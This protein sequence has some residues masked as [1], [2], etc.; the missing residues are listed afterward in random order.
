M[1]PRVALSATSP[2]NAPGIRTEPPASVP[3][4]ATPIPAL[5]A[6]AD[7]PL[8]PPGVSAGFHGLRVMPVS[9]ESVTAFHPN[10]G[11]VVFPRT[12][13]PSSRN[14]A[15]A[16]AS[17]RSE[18]CGST[19]RE[20]TNVGHSLVMI[21]SFTVIG[22]P[23]M[24]PTF[25]LRCQRSCAALACSSSCSG[26]AE[27]TKTLSP[28]RCSFRWSVAFIT[29]TGDNAPRFNC[30]TI[31]VKDKCEVV[32]DTAGSLPYA[33]CIAWTIAV[34]IRSSRQLTNTSRDKKIARCS[35]WNEASHGD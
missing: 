6:A 19:V 30:S 9:G 21:A 8:D 29:S 20:P 22:T 7:P 33:H 35:A 31:S 10:S 34:I 23:S 13:A 26:S 27:A 4:A 1:R 24:M 12:T 16:G 32:S 28:F 15:T 18:R 3:T 11:V 17:S 25:A 14:R 5:T 2:Q